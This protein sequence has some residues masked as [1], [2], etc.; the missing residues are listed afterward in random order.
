MYI[1]Y[2]IFVKNKKM[3]RYSMKELMKAKYGESEKNTKTTKS[4]KEQLIKL[5]LVL[6][7]NMLL[8]LLMVLSIWY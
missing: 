4:T 8:K 3:E 5:S 1:L 6:M 2:C 7:V